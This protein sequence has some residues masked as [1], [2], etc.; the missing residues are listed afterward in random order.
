MNKQRSFLTA[1]IASVIITIILF[2]LCMVFIYSFE[3]PRNMIVYTNAMEDARLK[4]IVPVKFSVENISM[5]QY[6]T[7]LIQQTW[8]LRLYLNSAIYSV[9]IISAQMLFGSLVAFS[10]SCFDIKFKN[11][12]YIVYAVLML[13]PFQVLI[14]PN[15]FIL[16]WIN[17]INT[18]LALM[19]PGIFGPFTVF[20]MRQY[21]ITLPRSLV[22]ATA[23]D[24]GDYLAAYRYVIM[25]MCKPSIVA[26]I[27][28]LFS[29]TWNMIEQP[30]VL[31]QN[32]MLYPL[33]LAL[34]DSTFSL[35]GSQYAAIILFA[36]PPLLLYIYFHEDLILGIQICDLK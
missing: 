28:L 6:H 35:G 27:T 21:M 22:E 34:V 32:R 13:M 20:I 19:L 9:V 8:Y 3:L 17:L 18:P 26:S 4:K 29:D 31:V 25:P 24:G 36:L 33:S 2:P 5:D 16:R 10:I 1:L 23:I 7:V 30:L 15:F 11:S 14:V 12:L